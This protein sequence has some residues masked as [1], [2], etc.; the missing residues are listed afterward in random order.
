MI[1]DDINLSHHFVAA[2]GFV[3]AVVAATG[4]V[5]AVVAA[6]GFVAAAGITSNILRIKLVY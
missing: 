4:F 3:A 2:T 6:T 5:A 1:L